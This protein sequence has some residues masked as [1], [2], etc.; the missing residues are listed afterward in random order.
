MYGGLHGLNWANYTKSF[1]FIFFIFRG[2]LRALG[3]EGDEEWEEAAEVKSE[4]L[5]KKE[6]SYQK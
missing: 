2:L 5:Q 4:I 3:V 6:S 1:F